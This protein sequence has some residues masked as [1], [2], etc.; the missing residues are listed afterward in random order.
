[1]YELTFYLKSGRDFH[2]W[3]TSYSLGRNGLGEFLKFSAIYA[4]NVC[5]RLEFV[6]LEDVDAIIVTD[7][8]DV[9]TKGQLP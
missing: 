9:P 7:E 6:N 8:K 1:M 5:P 4:Q 2:I 3:A